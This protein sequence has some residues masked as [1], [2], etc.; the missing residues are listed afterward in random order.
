MREALKGPALVTQTPA[1][2]EVGPR[3]RSAHAIRPERFQRNAVEVHV[4]GASTP[5]SVSE[6][7]RQGLTGNPKSLPPKYFYDA[8]GSALFDRITRLP[9]YYLTR[10]EQ[11]LIE[12]AA[13][14][15]MEE[16]RPTE[17][18]ELGSGSPV[19]VRSFLESRDAP[20][21]LTRYVPFDI[22]EGTVRA[23]AQAVVEAYPFLR[24][25]GVVGDFGSDLGHLPPAIGPRL[26]LFLGS[27]IGNLDPAPR[28]DLLAHVRGQLA[29]G[30]RL[31]LGVD[32]VKD[33]AVLEAAYNDPE[34]VTAEFN[35][36]I[37]RVVN[38]AVH[39]DFKPEAFVHRA[40]YDPRYCRIEMHLAPESAQEVSLRDLA[41]GVHVS[42]GETIWTESSYKFTRNST[43]AL[44]EEA[45]LRLEQWYTDSECRFGLALAGPG[46]AKAGP[47]A[48]F[49]A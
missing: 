47:P 27:T 21:Y 45:G 24:V 28:R 26:V 40:F 31:L 3:L 8:K 4:N 33:P 11:G 23:S 9:E 44:L 46:P 10:V 2:P 14:E 32:L 42:H 30:D 25:Y 36:N 39:G 13:R 29:P 49:T 34:G 20:D 7:I 5:A 35:R 18:V 17:V 19:K 12:G 22:D 1:A 6:D 38:R 43:Q 41:L 16:V 37:L 15:L 48:T